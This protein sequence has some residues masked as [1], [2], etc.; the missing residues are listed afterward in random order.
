MRQTTEEFITKAKAVWGDAYDYSRAVYRGPMRRVEIICPQHGSFRQ[1]PYNHLKR[2]GCRQCRFEASRLTTEQFVERARAIFGEYDYSQVDYQFTYIKVTII[3]PQHGPFERRP[4]ELLSKQWGCP[5]C[6]H[7]PRVKRG[8]ALK[9]EPE[10]L[11]II[12]WALRTYQP[13]LRERKTA[14]SF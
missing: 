13:A 1:F 10:E 12:R 14:E 2:H 4:T 6:C 7:R 11:A 5:V 3:C 9:L 8:P